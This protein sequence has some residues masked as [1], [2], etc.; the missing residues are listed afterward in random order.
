MRKWLTASVL[1]YFLYGLFM[2]WYLFVMSGSGV[3]E[4]YAG[5]SADPQTFMT[6]RELIL[7]EDYS[8]IKNFLYFVTVPFEW[9]IFFI[10]LLTGLSYKMQSWSNATSKFSAVKTSVYLFWLS[11]LVTV[12]ALPVEWLGYKISVS[13][14]ITTQAFPSWMKDQVIDFWVNY[15]MMILIV[16]VLLWL[17]RKYEKKWWLYAWFLSIP[18]SFFLMF[19]Q[20]VL[21]D[22]LYNDFYPLKNQQL[23]EKILALADEANIP[24]KHVYEVNMSE[25][26]NALNA[27]VTGVGSNSRIVLWDTTLNRLSDNEILFI[28]AHEMG[29][30][31]MKHIYVGVAGYLLLSLGGLYL[32]H[33]LMKLIIGRWGTLLKIKSIKDLTALPLFLMLIGILTFAS[34][35]L[36]NTVSRYQEKSAD[37]YAIEMTGDHEAAVTT[38]QELA[39]AGL[40]QVN[41][42]TLVKI[43]RYGHP[44]LFERI[45]YLED[46]HESKE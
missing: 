22:P 4:S 6:G 34:S 38:F 19:V 18:F 13:Y 37:M 20:P 35:P 40:S 31:V 36:T 17:I 3:P 33:R 15:L 11:L 45:N 23:E 24:A 30:Y 2:Y 25:K 27:Y 39:K 7:S 12:V 5:S 29:H 41:P 28:M 1:V 44:T 14:H 46:G 26:T 21:I 10:I 9:F 32:T 42:P 43:F 8:K 16:V